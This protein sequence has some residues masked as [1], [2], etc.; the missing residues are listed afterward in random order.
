MKKIF[1]G[2]LGAA[3]LML[4]MFAPLSASAWSY[5]SGYGYPMQGMQQPYA[6]ANSGYSYNN[7]YMQPPQYYPMYNAYSY[8]YYTLAYPSY[9]YAPTYSYSPSYTYAPMYS[10]AYQSPMV[11]IWNY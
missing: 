2:T 11:Y 9:Q 5:G 7:Y 1:T 4:G 8:P 6:Y 10:Y 3:A